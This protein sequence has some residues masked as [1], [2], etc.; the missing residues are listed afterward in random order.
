MGNHN[1]AV[2]NHHGYGKKFKIYKVDP[3]PNFLAIHLNCMK[4]AQRLYGSR[5]EF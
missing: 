4:E 3:Q 5:L 1:V 2:V